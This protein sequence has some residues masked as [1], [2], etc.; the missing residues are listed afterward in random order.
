MKI[1]TIIFWC[2]FTVSVLMLLTGLTRLQLFHQVVYAAENPSPLTPEFF[3]LLIGGAAALS[4]SLG[5]FLARF[6]SISLRD[7]NEMATAV[8]AGDL[9]RELPET[10]PRELAEISA[11]LNRL[12]ENLIS[13]DQEITK[14]VED[15][16]FAEKKAMEAAKTKSAFLAQMS[17]EFRTPLN[18]ILGY[19]Q[20]LLMDPG[21]SE[22]NRN[23]VRSLKA[24]GESLLELVNDVLD[25]TKIEAKGM[26]VHQSRFYLLEML[27]SIRDSYAEQIR[28]KGLTFKLTLDPE[29]PEDIL[30]D[31]VRLRQILVNLIGN[32]VKFTLRGG[33]ELRVSALET[34]ILFELEDSGIGIR[35]QDIPSIFQPFVQLQL[36]GNMQNQGT[37]LGLPISNRLLEVMGSTLEI[38]TQPG[39]GS[40]FYFLLPQPERSGRRMVIPTGKIMGYRGDIRRI[41]LLDVSGEA[42]PMLVPRLRRLEFQILESRS[43]EKAQAQIFEFQPHA[44]ILEHGARDTDAIQLMRNITDQFERQ[45]KSPPVFFVLTEHH[46][47]K[48]RISA[49]AAGAAAVI[50][51][52]LRFSDF[53]SLIEKHL[54]LEWRTKTDPEESRRQRQ[55]GYVLGDPAPPPELL[56]ELLGYAR[57][58]N[59][60]KVRETVRNRIAEQPTWE[61]FADTVLEHCA[62][63]QMKPLV[64][65]L[66][67]RLAS[68][69]EITHVQ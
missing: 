47:S 50:S 35:E 46:H 66:R 48:D 63:Y 15:R 26:I 68:D 10:G 7:I 17:H 27:E 9:S 51:K 49:L 3:I 24:S 25:L 54:H 33:I 59:V 30:S 67:Q 42:A 21:L 16:I 14:E 32:A 2:F 23:V 69:N 37:G 39:V 60:G 62:H 31:P 28:R 40:L 20:I 18:G 12:V 8:S 11:S 1:R 58:G 61:R 43:T 19:T 5:Y 13:A 53:V 65:M 38:D 64:E 44:V 34:G 41:F 36:P 55:M 22:K 6:I 52:P 57:A 29:L 56:R 45:E 4:M